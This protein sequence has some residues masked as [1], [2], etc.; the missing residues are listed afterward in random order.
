MSGERMYLFLMPLL[1]LSLFLF[2]DFTS[3]GV[4]RRLKGYRWSMT[5]LIIA[6]VASMFVEDTLSAGALILVSSFV[7]PFLRTRRYAD[8]DQDL[9]DF[10]KSKT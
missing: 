2:G 8:Q 7:A 9:K 6:I 3:R 10:T 1:A 5:V 4:I